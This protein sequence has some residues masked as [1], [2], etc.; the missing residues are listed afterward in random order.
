MEPQTQWCLPPGKKMLDELKEDA[1]VFIKAAVLPEEG[2]PPKLSIQEMVRMED[3]RVDL[4]SVISIR[5]WLKDEA[6][7]EKA[8][9]LHQLFGRKTGPT[10]V[11]L[12]LEKPRDFS[13]RPRLVFGQGPSGSR[14]SS[15]DREDLRP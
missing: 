5:I 2:G 12:R 8:G 6:A 10:D 11:R 9:E 4:P 3:A 13:S 7:I 15:R 14:V 1:A